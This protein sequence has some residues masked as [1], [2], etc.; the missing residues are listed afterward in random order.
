MRRG[1]SRVM[2]EELCEHSGLKVEC[3]SYCSGYFSQKVAAVMRRLS[4]IH[5][6]LGVGIDFTV[7]RV[8]TA[9]GSHHHRATRLAAVFNLP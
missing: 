1:Y 7:A 6:M 4:A 8:A 3:I 2:L 5:A 9:A